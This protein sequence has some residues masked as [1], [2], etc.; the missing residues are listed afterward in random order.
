MKAALLGMPEAG[1]STLFT[2]LTGRA[3]PPSRK[4]TEALEGKAPVRDERV[5]VMSRIV[6]PERKKYAETEFVLC[7]DVSAGSEKREWLEAAKKCDLLCMVVRAFLDPSVYHPDGS[8]S[9]ERD[10][11]HLAMELLLADLEIT[12]KRLER[13]EKEKRSGQTPA[14]ALEESALLKCKKALEKEQVLLQAGLDEKEIVALRTL[15]LVT[16]KPVVW[17]WN[18]D[19]KDVRED[20]VNPITI[21]CQIEKEIMELQDA[22]ERQAYLKDLGLAS[23]GVDRTNRAVYDTLG[24]MSFYTSGK[25][26]VRAWTVRKG[27]VAPVA[28]GKI[29]TDIQRGFIRVE[30]MKYDDLVEL[31]SEAA[32]KQS[33]RLETK[34]KDY[35]IQD[36]D[37]CHFLFNV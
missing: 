15:E 17:V 7:P 35:V 33:G 1:K 18:V 19:E 23:S 26:E 20:A 31:G 37:I 6:Q 32:V 12:D 13:I 25:D 14:Q 36:G 16:L 28:A 24:L 2:L 11:G 10:K 3:V 8:V 27:S 5:D 22:A 9:P 30:I 29:H 21:A 4:E 34:G